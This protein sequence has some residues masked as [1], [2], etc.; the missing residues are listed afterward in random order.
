MSTVCSAPS[1]T[2][3]AGMST[4]SHRVMYPRSDATPAFK[5]S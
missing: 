1:G 2:A 4:A 3:D 5:S